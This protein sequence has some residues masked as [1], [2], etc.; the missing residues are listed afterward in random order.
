MPRL[1]TS[2]SDDF[3]NRLR[4]FER[5]RAK[6]E[7][8]LL[9]GHVTRHDVS[10]FYEGIF[11]RTVTSFEGLLEELFISLLIG[12]VKAAPKIHPRVTFRSAAIA[13]DVML[14]GK[15][16]VDWLPYQ[17]TEKRANAFFRGG[18]PFCGL[19]K[20]EV[21]SLDRILTIRHAVAHQSRAARRRFENE[22][23]GLA[24]LLPTERTPAGFLRSVFSGPPPKTQY[25]DI[26]G[27]CAILARKLCT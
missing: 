18:L 23:I 1:A 7:R 16:Y 26:A 5:S 10:L 19:D 21:K 14:G 13:R 27:T 8:L 9:R 20:T 4:R 2:I 24:P 6:L 17:H 15:A 3:A 25:E 12:G 22:V 11:L